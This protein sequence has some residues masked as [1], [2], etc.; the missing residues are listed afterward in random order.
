M[1]PAVHAPLSE[2]AVNWRRRPAAYFHEYRLLALFVAAAVVYGV[3]RQLSSVL[4]TTTWFWSPTLTQRI[5][6]ISEFVLTDPRCQL[7]LALFCVAVYRAVI[8]IKRDPAGLGPAPTKLQVPLFT[9]VW[10][11]L[12]ATLLMA[13]V[14]FAAL[15]FGLS[16]NWWRFPF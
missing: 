2:P 12:L 11:A 10:A 13:V 5:E 16:V 14:I 7:W 4:T 3:S 6:Y 9:I 1:I 8:G 15:G